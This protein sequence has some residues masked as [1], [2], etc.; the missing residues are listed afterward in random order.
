VP[1][2]YD[3]L[4]HPHQH[5]KM[6]RVQ[7]IEQNR[8]EMAAYVGQPRDTWNQ[9]LRDLCTAEETAR[10][11]KKKA[12]L[13]DQPPLGGMRLHKWVTPTK[14]GKIWGPLDVPETGAVL[15]AETVTNVLKAVEKL[16]NRT[17][18]AQPIEVVI[19]GLDER[20]RQRM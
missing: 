9:K 6:L 16:T 20:Q 3:A 15:L 14:K 17:P 5:I 2:L 4:I 19:D 12:T 8:M 11:K 13:R 1:H 10:K 7:V 18:L